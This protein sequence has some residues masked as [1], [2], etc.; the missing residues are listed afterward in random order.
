MPFMQYGCDLLTQVSYH[1]RGKGYC[2]LRLHD[3]GSGNGGACVLA[4]RREYNLGCKGEKEDR[5]QG[6]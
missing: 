6:E 4:I 2:T 3:T 1:G 5:D